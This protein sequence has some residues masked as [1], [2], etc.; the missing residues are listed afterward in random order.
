MQEALLRLRE[1]VKRFRAAEPV[2]CGT[3]K[4]LFYNVTGEGWPAV[5]RETIAGSTILVAFDRSRRLTK[6][7]ER[8]DG[9]EPDA[10]R[11]LLLGKSMVAEVAPGEDVRGLVGEFVE[12]VGRFDGELAEAILKLR[13][14]QMMFDADDVG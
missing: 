9:T 10:V 13:V 4:E 1:E 7:V 5:V 6:T 12:T 2:D 14:A 11:A 8:V 3:D